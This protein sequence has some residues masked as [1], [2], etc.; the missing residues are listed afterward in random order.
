[1]VVKR[2]FPVV[3]YSWL[4][5]GFRKEVTPTS[6]CSYPSG[7]KKLQDLM[8]ESEVMGSMC[9]LNIVITANEI[10]YA[11]FEELKASCLRH[12]LESKG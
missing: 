3:V 2:C 5:T 6:L 11:T 10:S 7:G 4:W 9:V 12:V 1:M 8:L